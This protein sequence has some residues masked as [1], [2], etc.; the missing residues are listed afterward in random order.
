MTVARDFESRW[1]CSL[2]PEIALHAWNGSI[3][4]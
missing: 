2:G 4:V 1:G 3:R